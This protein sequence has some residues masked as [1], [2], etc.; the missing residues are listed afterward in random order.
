MITSIETNQPT[1]VKRIVQ[2]ECL[3]SISLLVSNQIKTIRKCMESIRPLLEQVPS[4]LVIVD[5]VGEEKSDGSLAIAKEYADK[6]VHFT[7]CD[8][9]AAARN[10]GLDQCQGQWFMFLD[11]DE[12]YDDVTPLID[13]FSNPDLLTTYHA[14]ST[15]N[16]NYESLEGKKFA[17]HTNIRIYKRNKKAKFIGKVHEHYTPTY[18]PIYESDAFVHHF[19]YIYGEDKLKRNEV[20]L[21]Q[22]IKENPRDYSAW[23]QLIIG[24]PKVEVIKK[25][26]LCEEAMSQVDGAKD[27]QLSEAKPFTEIIINLMDYYKTIGNFEGIKTLQ[28]EYGN[29]LNSDIFRKGLYS[30]M[31]LTIDLT[32]FQ[33]K[34]CLDYLRTYQEVVQYFVAHPSEYGSK[35]TPFFRN[36]MKAEH[37]NKVLV[38]YIETMYQ[39]KQYDALMDFI[40]MIDWSIFDVRKQEAIACLIRA[41][42]YQ[43]NQEALNRIVAYCEAND[44]ENEWI[45]ASQLFVFSLK[46]IK[47]QV[48]HQMIAKIPS[49]SFYVRYHQVAN[50][51]ISERLAQLAAHISYYEPGIEEYLI[52]C[53]E[54]NRPVLDC[55]RTANLGEIQTFA[56]FVDLYFE[57]DFAKEAKFIQQLADNLSEQVV[58]TYLV[59]QLL[60]QMLLKPSMSTTELE[61]YLESYLQSGQQLVVQLYS[62][63]IYRKEVM[64]LPNEF[65][66]LALLDQA[67]SY[68]QEGQFVLYLQTL[69]DGLAIYPEGKELIEKLMTL[70]QREIRK[71]QTVEDELSRLAD[72]VKADILKLISERNLTQAKAVYQ[73][74]VQIVPEDESLKMIYQLIK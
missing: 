47:K 67:L 45:A 46:P 74:L 43:G 24:Y 29:F 3:L 17:K 70:A 8:D 2:G 71:Q 40:S 13:F 72:K 35:Y 23:L 31:Q 60:K 34:H 14:V 12:Y 10:A 20:I 62:E 37:F 54:A 55:L 41:S 66:W 30:Y 21:R 11:D 58:G 44:L 57:G 51:P 7:W 73:E 27:I 50:A 48:F 32:L 9:F 49:E 19:G 26:Q 18:S 36:Y 69:K 61:N 15:K 42:Y 59:Y 65:H 28:E 52:T 4:E 16:R 56:K 1:K 68:H 5:T 22:M 25:I 38:T 39:S 64:L 63:P 33:Y 6:I 53:I